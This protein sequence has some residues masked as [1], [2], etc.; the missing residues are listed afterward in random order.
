[1]E[2]LVRHEQRLHECTRWRVEILGR[3]NSPELTRDL[4]F[5]P[6]VCGR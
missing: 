2:V 6:G 1:M 3:M 4:L 5:I